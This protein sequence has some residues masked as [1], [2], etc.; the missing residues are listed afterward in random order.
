[1]R[2]CIKILHVIPTEKLYLWHPVQVDYILSNRLQCK[3]L[4][5][6]SNF[7]Q[8]DSHQSDSPGH[9]GPSPDARSWHAVGETR[10]YS[11]VRSTLR[12][13]VGFLGSKIGRIIFKCILKDIDY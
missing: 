4:E 3:V 6:T 9:C 10:A 5:E 7:P 13:N 8:T 1:M 12:G 11:S 2:N